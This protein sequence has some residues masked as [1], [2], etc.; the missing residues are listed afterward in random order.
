[1]AT[2]NALALPTE[3]KRSITEQVARQI[4]LRIVSGALPINAALPHEEALLA[5]LGVSRTV[6]RE[7]FKILSAKGLLEARQK[8]GTIVRPRADW[9][10]IDPDVL[11]WLAEC[12]RDNRHLLQLMEVRSIVEPEAARLAAQRRTD[13]DAQRILHAAQRMEETVGSSNDFVA[14]D[15]AFHKSILLAAKN[16]LLV[17]IGNVILNC[18]VVSLRVTNA[19]TSG[20]HDSQVLHQAV[21][22][23]IAA[24][25]ADGALA[26]MTHLLADAAARIGS[27]AKQPAPLTRLKDN[28]P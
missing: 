26:A 3:L 28:T 8:R 16:D 2:S 17:P 24:R 6:L 10:A 13:A 22:N 18:L 21:A 14:A 20:N 19:K 1:M 25:D 9:N 27:A 12:S 4:A 5:E 23:A 15:I 11:S 7:A